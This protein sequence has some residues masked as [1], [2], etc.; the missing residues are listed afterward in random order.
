M[1][2]QRTS[3]EWS[4]ASGGAAQ[5]PP[6]PPM[7]MQ[8]R[9]LIQQELARMMASSAGPAAPGDGQ[10]PHSE[11]AGPAAQPAAAQGMAAPGGMPPG[12]AAAMPWPAG[13]A[14]MAMPQ[15]APGS[16]QSGPAPSGPAA[17]GSAHAAS[18]EGPAPQ[19]EELTNRLADNLRKLKAVLA[20]TQ[21]IAKQMEQLLANSAK[22]QRGQG[23]GGHSQDGSPASNQGNGGQ[24]PAQ[25]GPSAESQRQR[26]WGSWL[27][28]R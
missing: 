20:E 7:E 6:A 16:P 9:W 27:S 13:P 24:E 10:S 17:Y 12:G 15:A 22:G 26:P 14:Q 19:E 11:G 25:G 8:L 18:P 21:S 23:R 5:L 2:E 4:P 28:L 1:S 3:Q